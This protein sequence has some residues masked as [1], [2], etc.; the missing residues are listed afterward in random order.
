MRNKP[1][2]PQENTL[3]AA[4]YALLAENQDQG[5]TT[6]KAKLVRTLI[7]DWQT[8]TGMPARSRGSIEAKFMNASAIVS[9]RGWLSH[10]PNGYVKGY[11][12]APNYQ[13]ALVDALAAALGHVASDLPADDLR[14]SA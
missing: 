12:P 6:N 14:V 8:R 1:Y 10:L 5:I 11:K 4:A 9:E 13:A 3:I 7:A 2:T